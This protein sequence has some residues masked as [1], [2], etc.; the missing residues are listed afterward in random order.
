MWGGGVCADILKLVLGGLRKKQALK[1]GMW[2]TAYHLAIA[3]RKGSVNLDRSG[4]LHPTSTS[5]PIFQCANPNR[6]FY[7]CSCFIYLF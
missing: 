5:R 1:R 4:R 6:S 7:G 3:P 2:L